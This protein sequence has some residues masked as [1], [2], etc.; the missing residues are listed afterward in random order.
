MYYQKIQIRYIE[1]FFFV[2][3]SVYNHIQILLRKV[4]SPTYPGYDLTGFNCT[5]LSFFYKNYFYK[6]HEAQIS[7]NLIIF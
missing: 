1:T 5:T 6:N 2:L 4:I 7:K 3:H